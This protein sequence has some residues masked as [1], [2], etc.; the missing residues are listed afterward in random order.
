[1]TLPMPAV[2][3]ISYLAATIVLLFASPP[4][5]KATLAALRW[6]SV[7]LG[8]LP[9]MVDIWKNASADLPKRFAQAKK[10]AIDGKVA[11][12]TVLGVNLVDVEIIDRGEIKSRDM[13]YTSFAHSFALAIGREGFRVYQA[14]QTRG[15]RFDQYL[16]NGGSRLRSWAES[17][18]FL[19]NFKILSRPQKKWS[20]E[21]NSAYA[22]CFE[23]NI[24]LICGEGHMNPP[25]IPV[26]RPWVRVFEI[27]EVKI[28]DIKK[29]KWE[30]SV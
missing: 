12:V 7:Q 21:L 26:Y 22:E 5:P 15:L 29:F 3:N 20:P 1:M 11:K 2:W 17:K 13:D 8:G 25:I 16:M 18:S 4:D 27:N 10:A 9:T 30:G 14:W 28:E 19:R 6:L 23:V 24:D